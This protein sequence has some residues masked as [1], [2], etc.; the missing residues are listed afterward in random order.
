MKK[1]SLFILLGVFILQMF[2][3]LN[4]SLLAYAGR[5]SGGQVTGAAIDP[6]TGR[7]DTYH[8][9]KVNKGRGSGSSHSGTRG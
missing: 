1:T 2:I 4:P 3:N 5:P 7:T 8:A 6:E 9:P